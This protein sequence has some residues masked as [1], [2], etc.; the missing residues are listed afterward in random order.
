MDHAGGNCTWLR[1]IAF[2]PPACLPACLPLSN[3]CGPLMIYPGMSRVGECMNPLTG[4]NGGHRALLRNSTSRGREADGGAT[5][6]GFINHSCQEMKSEEVYYALTNNGARQ[7]TRPQCDW[8]L[9][10]LIFAPE[11]TTTS[12]DSLIRRS[13]FRFPVRGPGVGISWTPVFFYQ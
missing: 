7:L 13:I 5:S 9:D 8:S 4:R 3:L 2:R 1:T 11:P 10:A 6:P 12:L